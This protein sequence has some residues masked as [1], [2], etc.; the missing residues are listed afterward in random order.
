VQA[1]LEEA[2]HRLGLNKMSVEA[3]PTLKA[4]A[5][6]A[7]IKVEGLKQESQS[8]TIVLAGLQEEMKELRASEAKY[9]SMVSAGVANVLL[10]CF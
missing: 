3:L 10:M 1:S 4:R 6:D 9:S 5:E 2:N 8:L 7:E